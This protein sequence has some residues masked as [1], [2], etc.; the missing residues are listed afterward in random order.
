MKKSLFTSAT[1]L[2]AGAVIALAAPLAASAHD[3]IDPN[4]SD[5]G[6]YP[7]ITFKVPTE[8]ATATTTKI[9]L[10]LPQDTPFGFASYTPDDGWPTATGFAL[11]LLNDGAVGEV[12][13]GMCQSTALQ[14]DAGTQIITTVNNIDGLTE[15]GQEQGFL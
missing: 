15:F 1:A 5:P 4:Q 13:L 7:L 2:I 10:T 8:S 11:D 14:R 12:D 9:E 3:G 6:T